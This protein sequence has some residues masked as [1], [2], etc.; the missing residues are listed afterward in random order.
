M[1][2]EQQIKVLEQQIAR[3]QQTEGAIR[4]TIAGLREFELSGRTSVGSVLKA[5]LEFNPDDF[6]EV[7]VHWYRL[8]PGGS[9]WQ[10]VGEVDQRSYRLTTDDLGSTLMAVVAMQPNGKEVTRHQ[11]NVMGPIT[12]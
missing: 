6:T 10:L 8:L 9:G 4:Q 2:P 11:S 1:K 12:K 3:D 5:S 7:Q